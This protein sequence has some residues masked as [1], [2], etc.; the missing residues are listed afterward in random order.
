LEIAESKLTPYTGIASEGFSPHSPQLN[1]PY[2]GPFD[3]AGE[4]KTMQMRRNS[5]R[6]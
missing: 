2:Q 6:E 5:S 4:A 1:Y 3:K